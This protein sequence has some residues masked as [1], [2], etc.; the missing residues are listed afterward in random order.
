MR[1]WLAIAAMLLAV[2][3]HAAE[4]A[5]I[6]GTISDR[7]THQPIA[8]ARVVLRYR[9]SPAQLQTTTSS[10]N[11]AY[12][13]DVESAGEYAIEAE[14]PSYVP[15]D[16]SQQEPFAKIE[17]D[18]TTEDVIPS[19]H[20]L[21]VSLTRAASMVG[22]LKDGK[23]QSPVR[24]IAIRLWEMNWRR[25]ERVFKENHIAFTADDGRFRFD[26]LAPADYFIEINSHAES[27]GFLAGPQPEYT[28]AFPRPVAYPTVFWPAG[29]PDTGLPFTIRNSGETDIGNV[30]ISR[31][32]LGRIGID[33]GSLDCQEGSVIDLSVGRKFGWNSGRWSA[34]GGFVPCGQSVTAINL[35]P[36]EYTIQAFNRPVG[37][38]LIAPPTSGTFASASARVEEGA[39]IDVDLASRSAVRISGAVDC[40]CAE[41]W[42]DR[43][44]GTQVRLTPLAPGVSI[45]YPES[46]VDG[47]GSFL[48][49][50]AFSGL[51]SL[52][53]TRRFQHREDPL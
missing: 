6:D 32:P 17:E 3:A 44:A 20:T 29:D 40:Q 16:Y 42:R 14:A 43:V 50:G 46:R 11:G 5:R 4:S 48:V 35:S 39:D 19:S 2:P 1:K 36:G 30:P 49:G 27:S 53:P 24:G 33:T 15:S 26:A 38:T 22:R 52:V 47:N 10:T 18:S 12:R 21:D 34:G 31:I 25:G 23:S 7:N 13:F 37:V 45:G 9:T 8:E 41:G 28:A 51:V